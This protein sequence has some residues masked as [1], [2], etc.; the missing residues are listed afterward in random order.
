M[1]IFKNISTKSLA[2]ANPLFN[3]TPYLYFDTSTYDNRENLWASS[4][5][6]DSTVWTLQTD[7]TGVVGIGQNA[8]ISP[9]NLFITE[10]GKVKL[11]GF[12]FC[13]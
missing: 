1:A 9:E 3:P 4:N 5:T 7:G 2:Q 12:N 8:I 6:F 13:A 11:G 10:S